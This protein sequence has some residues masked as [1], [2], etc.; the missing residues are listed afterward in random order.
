MGVE[1]EE[2]PPGALPR[3][4]PAWDELLRVSGANRIFLSW[5]WMRAWADTFGAPARPLFLA[6]RRGGALVGIA[7]L[8][9][10]RMLG[11]DVV[12]FASATTLY[13]DYLDFPV[14]PSA[15]PAAVAALHEYVFARFGCLVDLGGVLEESLLF[16]TREQWGV[17]FRVA[18]EAVSVCPYLRLPDSY[19]RLVES[20]F[21]RKKRYNLLRQ[22]R[23]A[24]EHGFRYVAA[25][26]EAEAAE[27]LGATFHLHD[28]R[29][30]A[31]A[32]RSTFAG[33][34][35]EAFHR[36]LLPALWP[37]GRVWL[38]ALRGAEG[39]IAAAAYA[40]CD[41]RKLYYYQTGSA[42]R[43]DHLGLGTVLLGLLIQECCERG[44]EEFDFLQ[45]DE[46]Y[47][48]SWSADRRQ[49]YRLCLCPRNLSG[50]LVGA[51][52]RM[53]GRLA[54]ARRWATAPRSRATV[55]G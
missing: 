23:I 15:G 38:R 26:S 4:G 32:I 30:R 45:G 9:L 6:A 10:E 42:P 28:L 36:R 47:K 33:G 54:V 44:L 39:E 24:L 46:A 11:Q 35:V 29:A 27:L 22:Q 43:H 8:C 40:F 20:R 55:E 13:P 16:R 7:P 3:L 19:E 48:R 49:L 51:L 50:A 1:I 17:R 21:K 37:S 31:R 25:Q 2:L 18:V 5:E 53:K 52:L 12:R 14:E 41:G 34:A